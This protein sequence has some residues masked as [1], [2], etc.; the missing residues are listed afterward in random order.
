MIQQLIAYGYIKQAYQ[1][2][3]PM[4]ERVRVNDGFFEWY[5]IDN[6]PSG[7]GTFRG[8]AGVLDKAIQMFQNWAKEQ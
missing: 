1:E 6:K 7:S 3:L 2:C 4:L 5:T 8:S